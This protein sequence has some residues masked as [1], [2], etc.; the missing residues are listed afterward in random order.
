MDGNQEAGEL[1]ADLIAGGLAA[2][3]TLEGVWPSFGIHSF[4]GY[5]D[6]EDVAGF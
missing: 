6:K 5:E 2:L 1:L 3:V 4:Q